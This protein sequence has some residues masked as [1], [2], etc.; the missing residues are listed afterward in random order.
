MNLF[1]LESRTVVEYLDAPGE[2]LSMGEKENQERRKYITIL[3][4][5]LLSYQSDVPIFIFSQG[6]LILSKVDCYFCLEY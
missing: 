2:S 3:L 6:V 5:I 1:S 4:H